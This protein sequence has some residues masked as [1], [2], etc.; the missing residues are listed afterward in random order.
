MK[1]VAHRVMKV[2]APSRMKGLARVLRTTEGAE[3]AEAAVVLPVA[4]LFIMG[5]VWFGRAFNIYSTIQQAAQQ[6]AIAAARPTCATCPS[7][8]GGGGAVDTAVAAV[9]SA[10]NIDPTQIIAGSPVAPCTSS[11]AYKITVCA[12]V[13][14]NSSSPTT[15]PCAPGPSPADFCGM[16]VTFQYPFT[17]NVPFAAP[18]INLTA[19]AQSRMEN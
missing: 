17:F 5:I 4:F 19:Q 9:M 12:Q 2:L 13:Q 1:S 8:F 7:S 14:L 11:P 16:L 10:S 6:G 18:T 3:I 15:T